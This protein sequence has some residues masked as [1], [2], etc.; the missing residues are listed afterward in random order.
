MAFLMCSGPTS[1]AIAQDQAAATASPAATQAPEPLDEDELEVLVARIALYPDELVAVISE[2]SLYPLQ[3]VEASRFLDQV[4]KKPGLKPKESWD[5]SVVSLLNY[6]DI[7]KMM[8]DDLEWTQALG[9]ALTYQQKDVLVAIQQLRDTA[10]AKGVIKSDD[11]I[12]VVEENDNVVIRSASSDKVYVPRYEPEM[13]YATDYPVAPIS[14]YPD[15]YP[16]YYY[17]TAPYFA[18]FVTGAVW[19][20]AVD[21]NGGG[22]WGGRWNGNDIDIDCNNCFNNIN[23]KVNFN[24][25]DWK[26]VDRSKLNFDKNQF[27]NIDK[28]GIGNRVKTNDRNNM[29]DKASEL[30]RGQIS[31]LPGNSAKV[32][33]I[34]QRQIREGLKARPPASRPDFKRPTN[35][36]PI[37]S[38]RNND[39]SAVRAPGKINRP[40]GK[41]RPA[42]RVDN[43]PRNPSGLGNVSSG[44]RQQI[45]SNRGARSMGGGIRS[46]GGGG[47]KMIRQGGGRQSGGG[48]RR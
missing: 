24:D 21:W 31:A 41:P 38:A 39:R 48:R 37:A 10:V 45:A 20:A 32:K 8:S 46:G 29:R 28:T 3:I 17:P 30:R 27:A 44:K 4:T 22:V 23:G 36:K 19:A 6:P 18:A 25:V 9:D 33:D 1:F 47:H 26:N 40:V 13:L 7:V 42:A 11:K 15:P 12:K 34:R 43:R 5:G 14:Y 16:S 2:A 35:T